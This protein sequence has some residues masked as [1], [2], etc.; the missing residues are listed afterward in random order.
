MAQ[1]FI[2]AV[3]LLL[4]R[5]RLKSKAILAF[6]L[7][8]F[9]LLSFKILLHTLGLWNQPFWRYFPL[10]IDLLIQPLFYFYTIFLTQKNAR[11]YR[12]YLWHFL[13]VFLFLLHAMV[14]YFY[15]QK[16]D[17][18][19]TKNLYAEQFYYNFIK[20]IEDILSII[21]GIIYWFLSFLRIKLYKKW[22]D[23]ATSN[24]SYPSYNWVR[25][26]LIALGVLVVILMVNI[27]TEIFFDLGS[28]GFFKWQFFYYY[29]AVLVYYLGFVG[30]QQKDFEVELTIEKRT[31]ISLDEHQIESVKTKLEQAIYQDKIYLDADLSLASL[32]QKIVVSEAVIS[33]VINTIYHKNFRNFINEHRVEEVKRML[34]DSRNKHLSILG[35]ALESGFN[36]EAS[37][38]RIFKSVTGKSPKE[39]ITHVG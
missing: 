24:V 17:N 34:S 12:K 25:N 27:L 8:T 15:T 26:V 33:V 10:G 19:A 21:S 37:F 16:T 4:H 7:L 14:V 38:Y 9:I 36:S 22:L 6:I 18:I 23:D 3:L 29:L 1:G 20:Q 32:S 31:P 11:F 28:N 39:F 5:P 35:I 30:Y 13:P 2:C